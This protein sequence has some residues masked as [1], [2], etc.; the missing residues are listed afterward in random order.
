MR[1]LMKFKVG[2]DEESGTSD[3]WISHL[4]KRFQQGFSP[5][6]LSPH[7]YSTCLLRNWTV[8]R[9]YRWW[10]AKESW[11]HGFVSVPDTMQCTEYPTTHTSFGNSKALLNLFRLGPSIIREFNLQ[12]PVNNKW[13]YEYEDFYYP[14]CF[15][16]IAAL[17][18]K[19]HLFTTSRRT[20]SE[21]AVHHR[22]GAM[23][24][25]AYNWQDGSI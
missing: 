5:L 11:R 15:I 7:R 20:S 4:A 9:R 23:Y 12:E 19:Q 3:W 6:Q 8:E 10:Y 17:F 1:S 2:T 25:G 18:R 21:E 22:G 13:N 14:Q 16:W 24:L